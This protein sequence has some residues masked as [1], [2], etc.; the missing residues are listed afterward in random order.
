MTVILSLARKCVVVVVLLLITEVLA[1]RA[2]MN[3]PSPGPVEIDPD[4]PPRA[5][6]NGHGDGPAPPTNAIADPPNEKLKPELRVSHPAS[7]V[8]QLLE[9]DDM[10]RN[11]DNI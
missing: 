5:I 4:A 7:E 10:V 2:V 9:E 6:R 1:N 8:I 11:N 3:P